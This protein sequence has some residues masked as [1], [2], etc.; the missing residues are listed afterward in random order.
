M[1]VLSQ[2]KFGKVC[3]VVV[4]E[5]PVVILIVT[6]PSGSQVPFSVGVSSLVVGGTVTVIKVVLSIIPQDGVAVNEVG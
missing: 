4:D 1:L 5:L 2:V 3:C 6:T